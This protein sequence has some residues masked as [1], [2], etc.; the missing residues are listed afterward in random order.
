M[1]GRIVL[2][3]NV[4][5]GNRQDCHDVQARTALGYSKHELPQRTRFSGVS[6]DS[7]R[8]HTFESVST[9]PKDPGTTIMW[10][11]SGEANP[12]I[13]DSER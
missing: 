3:K 13:E 4:M 8:F 6:S 5:Q 11:V 2:T 7:K 9:Y 10:Q 1:C 12:K